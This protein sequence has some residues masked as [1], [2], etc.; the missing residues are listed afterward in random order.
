MNVSRET[1]KGQSA[2]ALGQKS[3]I[4]YWLVRGGVVRAGAPHG[5]IAFH[6]A[7]W[8]SRAWRHEPPRDTNNRSSQIS[9]TTL[10]C[11]I[12]VGIHRWCYGFMFITNINIYVRCNG[13]FILLR[14]YLASHH[15]SQFLKIKLCTMSFF[16]RSTGRGRNPH[17]ILILIKVYN[18]FEDCFKDYIALTMTEH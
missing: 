9:S 6:Y 1:P 16:Y 8:P 2:S 5:R 12:A 10:S 11:Q 3:G 18:R 17:L 15:A 13:I 7:A 14:D 4:Q